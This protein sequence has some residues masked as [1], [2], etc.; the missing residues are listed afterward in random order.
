MEIAKT[1]IQPKEGIYNTRFGEL[2]FK[3]G[4]W[5]LPNLTGTYFDFADFKV[6][7]YL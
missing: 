6:D 7:W 1:F 5:K 3:D 2:R 4:L